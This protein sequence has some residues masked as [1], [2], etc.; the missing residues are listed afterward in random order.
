MSIP[1]SPERR[2]YEAPNTAPEDPMN[3]TQAWK[4]QLWNVSL[5]PVC[6]DRRESF[7]PPEPAPRGGSSLAR[8]ALLSVSEQP[9]ATLARAA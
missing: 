4:N 5:F 3:R 8:P 7:E 9:V 6:N 1:A 2:P